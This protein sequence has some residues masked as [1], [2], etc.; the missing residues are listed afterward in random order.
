VSPGVRGG[1]LTV[2]R[3]L[4]SGNFSEPDSAGWFAA[5][6]ASIVIHTTCAAARQYRAHFTPD[7]RKRQSVF[8]SVTQKP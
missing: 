2:Q 4:A 3:R 1:R 6:L 5:H 7:L 8:L